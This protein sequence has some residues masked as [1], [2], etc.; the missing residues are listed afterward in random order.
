MN[1]F[2]V[3]NPSSTTE[4]KKRYKMCYTDADTFLFR[5][6]KMMQEDYVEVRHKASGRTME[7]RNLT[8][9]GVRS[10]KIIELTEEDISQNK[11]EVR[12]DS[13]VAE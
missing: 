5:C 1:D 12:K 10:G 3:V 2:V 13:R 11:R 9:F 8:S 4:N 7:F 6:V